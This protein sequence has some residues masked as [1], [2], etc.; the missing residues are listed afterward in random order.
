MHLW[1]KPLNNRLG[2]RS[3]TS[4]LKIKQDR[5]LSF[6]SFF[7]PLFESNVTVADSSENDK[8]KFLKIVWTTAT[9]DPALSGWLGVRGISVLLQDDHCVGLALSGSS[10]DL[11]GL[12]QWN[13]L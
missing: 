12:Y 4:A 13:A 7:P 8:F 10:W 5:D 2:S 6:L 11:D 3:Q 9:F 1:Q